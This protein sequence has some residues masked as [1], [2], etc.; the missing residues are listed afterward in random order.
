MS[1]REWA[2]NQGRLGSGKSAKVKPQEQP[3][4]EAAT[5]TTATGYLH[6]HILDVSAMMS[7][8]SHLGPFL[9]LVPLSLKGWE[10]KFISLFVLGFCR[11]TNQYD[12]ILF[13][14]GLLK[15]LWRLKSL[16]FLGQAGSLEIQV[17]VDVKVLNL[18]STGQGSQRFYVAVMKLKSFSEKF[19]FALQASNWLMKFS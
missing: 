4:E 16:K 7:S 1:F 3:K 15:W 13:Y 10:R 9:W 11:E 5:D 8:C 14:W 12:T 17:R 19:A 6:Q 18:N 2:E